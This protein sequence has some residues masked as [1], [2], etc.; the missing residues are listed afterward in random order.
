MYTRNTE[1]HGLLW[2]FQAPGT[3]P[4]LPWSALRRMFGPFSEVRKSRQKTSSSASVLF[5][6][7]TDP[8]LS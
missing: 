7:Y 5:E 6:S 4:L 1:G 2:T 8:S 3:S